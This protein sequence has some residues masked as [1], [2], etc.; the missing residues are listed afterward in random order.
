MGTRLISTPQTSGIFIFAGEKM[1]RVREMIDRVASTDATIFIQGE[2]G[3][4]KEV[5]ARSIHLQSG[6]RE[7]PFLKVNCGAQPQ[8][9]L[10]SELFG[11]ER[12]AFVGAFRQKPGK[13]ELAAGGT[14]FLDEIGDIP[15]SLQAKLLRVLQDLE[16]CRLGGQRAIRSDVRLLAATTRNIKEAAVEAW[17]Q[18]DLYYKL[19]VV[20][21]AIPPL[22]ERKEE[23][24]VFAE[25]F[26]KKF[27]SKYKKKATPISHSF[28][29]A[30]LAHQW[31]GNIREL[32]NVIQR[33]VF[34][35]NE[36]GIVGQLGFPAKDDGPSHVQKE[37]NLLPGNQPSLKQIHRAAARKA[38]AKVIAKALEM[39]NYNRKKAAQ[40]LNVSYKSL[41]YSIQKC[42]IKK[43]LNSQSS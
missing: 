7:K 27:E 29:E 23:I 9:L 6:R 31:P 34:L 16:F 17:F 10:E 21:I 32:Q 35:A 15:P 5:V 30:L 36:E 24:P 20:S 4:G 3:V 38:E 8:E 11:Y 2:S 13:L 43:R 14:I 19:K 33:Y 12:G 37:E 42:G 41:I 39:T 18:D 26:L 25:N 40:L 22:R 1:E 28:M